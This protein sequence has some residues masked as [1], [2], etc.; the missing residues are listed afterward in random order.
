MRHTD[1]PAAATNQKSKTAKPLHPPRFIL[2]CDLV[3]S[4][5]Q[6]WGKCVAPL[7]CCVL[8]IDEATIHA[9]VCKQQQ[10]RH[11]NRMLG[12]RLFRNY[13]S[14]DPSINQLQ[15]QLLDTT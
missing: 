4:F 5:E 12:S 3:S 14:F 10:T 7:C 1:L 8:V 13:S 6:R 9:C 15:F 2:T 11:A